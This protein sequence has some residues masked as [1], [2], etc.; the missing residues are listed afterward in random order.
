MDNQEYLKISK[1]IRN[2]KIARMNVLLFL[3]LTV[4][5]FI[6]ITTSGRYLL[7]SIYTCLSCGVVGVLFKETYGNAVLVGCIVA[8]LVIL[9]V[10]FIMWLFS[11]KHRWAIIVLLLLVFVGCVLLLVDAISCLDGGGSRYA[12]RRG[13][14]TAIMI[15][16]LILGIKASGNLQ[17]H[18]PQGVTLT[19]EQ[20]NEAYRLENGIDPVSGMHVNSAPV[21]PASGMPASSA[22]AA[23]NSVENE[24]ADPGAPVGYDPMTGEPIYAEKADSDAPSVMIL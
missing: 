11:K 13:P 2:Y 8:G 17:K 20:L 7:F 12:C 10:F 16:Y 4:V 22:A 9:A 23:G 19:T 18:F 3:A 21:D 24:K 14:F 6:M 1:E 5:N 15:Y